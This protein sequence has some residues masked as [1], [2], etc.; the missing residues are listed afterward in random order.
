MQVLIIH[1]GPVQELIESAR[2][3]RDLWFGSWLLS[4]LARAA[5]RGIVDAEGRA[6]GD[7]LVFPGASVA[8][9]SR[10]VANRIV[11]RINGP[12]A[13]VA[14]AAERAMRARLS[15][16][17][18][19]AFQ[20]V[21]P[22][23]P[24]RAELFHEETAREQVDS[25]I[26]LLWASAER[27]E[28][29]DA[30]DQAD[31]LLAAVKNTKVWSQPAWAKDG[32]PKSSLD[33]IRESVLDEALFDGR[34]RTGGEAHLR[35]SF[36]VH[37]SERLCGVG[38]LKR[39]GRTKGETDCPDRI[40]S[41]S[42][43]ASGP[44]R[45]GLRRTGGGDAFATFQR[46]LAAVDSELTAAFETS[47]DAD[48]I[49]G[50]VDGA[51]FYEGRLVE[52]LEEL[53]WERD[54]E[55]DRPKFERAR[56]ALRDFLRAVRPI[57]EPTP[58]Y[59]ILV[60][61][62][63]RMGE[64]LAELKRF[65][66]HRDLS[67]AL[68]DFARGARTTVTE[69]EGSL[70]YSGGDDVLALLPLHRALECT[71]NLAENFAKKLSCFALGGRGPTLSA[72]LAIVHH[73]MPLDESLALARATEKRAKAVEGKN[74]LA[75]SVKKRGGEAV[76][77]A[78]PWGAIDARLG[79]LIELHR[80]GA[81]SARTQYELVDLGVR[82]SQGCKRCGHEA[83][84]LAPV[85]EAESRRLLARKRARGGGQVAERT[86]DE[87]ERHGAFTDPDRL[88]RE[89]YVAQLFARAKEQA[90]PTP[91]RVEARALE[92]ETRP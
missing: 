68:E 76:T 10:A 58:Y 87:L 53:G 3:C 90:E 4:E 6:E 18:D 86:L 63:D 7:V 42:H 57:G 39:F 47:F 88:G 59:A 89:L 50:R 37:G 14:A 82:L 17:R 13:E 54:Y 16:L 51:V 67:G 56:K 11:A 66:E 73:L 71:A 65:E 20:L 45:A 61:D 62:G 75:V 70:V 19:Q 29:R 52:E 85:R 21:A 9:T 8:D 77:V 43:V 25:A 49:T 69:H 79:K 46:E 32:V 30:L 78:D 44:F 35:R 26:E 24:R 40:F 2:K 15:E 81:I 60:A 83:D 22:R 27:P 74:A 34:S 28:Y 91:A 64:T 23:H 80:A 12:A 55:L 31:R 5:A 36:G 48:P 72:G 41:T 92:Q 1:I 84:A 38:V 33:G